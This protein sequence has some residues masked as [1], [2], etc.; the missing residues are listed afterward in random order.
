M[1]FRHVLWTQERRGEPM[2]NW[3][4]VA[5]LVYAMG[6]VNWLRL[7]WDDLKEVERCPP[8]L[9]FALAVVW[10]MALFIWFGGLFAK[11]FGWLVALRS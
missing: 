8:I 3:F 1:L 6:G 9:A 5:A 4:Y 7:A 2:N 10:P 11:A